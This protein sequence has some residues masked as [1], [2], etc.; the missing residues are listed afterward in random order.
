MGILIGFV[1]TLGCV[2]GGFMAMGGHLHVLMQ[3]WELVIIGGA[4]LG[5]FLV[6]NPMKTVKDTGRAI[7]EAIRQSVPSEREYLETL[8]VLHSL[9]RELRSKSRSEVEAHIDNPEESAIFQA[10]P[11]VLK[12]KDLTNFICDYCRI[13][14]IGNARSY[15]IE[16]LMDEEIQT[17]RADKLKAYHSM[18]AVGDALP[19]L[20]I[21][22]AVLGVVKAMGAL[23]QSPEILGGLIGAAL[24]GTF[25]GIFLSYAVVGPVASKIKVVREKQNR[26]YIIVKQTLLAYMNGSLPQVAIEFGRKTISSYDRPSIDAVEQSTMNAVIAEKKAA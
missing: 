23:D 17:I 6:A 1:V 13:I 20:G 22:A 19:A 7:M 12:N 18:V 26:L 3:P 10:F 8:G 21:V 25:L 16:A 24:V 14:I 9:M 4:A 5:A 2:L 15:E 11:T